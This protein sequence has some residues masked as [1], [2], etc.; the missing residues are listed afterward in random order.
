[1]NQ[2]CGPWALALVGCYSDADAAARAVRKLTGRRAI[3]GMCREEM[4]SAVE[5]SGCTAVCVLVARQAP[6]GEFPTV[7]RFRHEHAH[8]RF[9]LRVRQHYIALKDGLIADNQHPW[10]RD[11]WRGLNGKRVREAWEVRP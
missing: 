7:E 9:I 4:L 5:A 10:W 8:G 1:M 6:I 3:F 11:G 2:F